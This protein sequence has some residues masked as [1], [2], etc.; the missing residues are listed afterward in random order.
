MSN[1]FD[2]AM[3]ILQWLDE[4]RA[5]PDAVVER[6][7]S[8]EREAFLWHVVSIHMSPADRAGIEKLAADLKAGGYRRDDATRPPA[9]DI[10]AGLWAR[11]KRSLT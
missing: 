4:H 6:I 5:E 10:P 2:E 8:A 7:S 11:I 3:E 1:P 9:P